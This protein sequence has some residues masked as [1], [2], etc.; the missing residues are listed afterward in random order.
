MFAFFSRAIQRAVN[1]N[2]NKCSARPQHARIEK[3]HARHFTSHHYCGKKYQPARGAN[4]RRYSNDSHRRVHKT[5]LFIREIAI[6]NTVLTLCEFC[7]MLCA[8]YKMLAPLTWCDNVVDVL[9][10]FVINHRNAFAA[11]QT[12]RSVCAFRSICGRTSWGH[13]CRRYFCVLFCDFRR[14]ASAYVLTLILRN[15]QLRY[16]KCTP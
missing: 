11:E 14:Q 13:Q 16:C 4:L 9:L 1:T 6:I 2:H 3:F 7:G 15:I 10:M 5:R 12:T 8:V